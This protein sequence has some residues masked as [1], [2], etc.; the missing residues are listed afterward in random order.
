MTC[1]TSCRRGPAAGLPA[2]PKTPTAGP[3]RGVS[4]APGS[5]RPHSNGHNQNAVSLCHVC[6]RRRSRP[7]RG[8]VSQEEDDALTGH[9]SRPA[10]IQSVG[11]GDEG[12]GKVR[13]AGCLLV[14]DHG[15]RCRHIAHLP[16]QLVGVVGKGDDGVARG[17]RPRGGSRNEGH[18]K[19]PGELNIGRRHA[20]RLVHGNGI[21]NLACDVWGTLRPCGGGDCGGHDGGGSG[22]GHQAD[23]HQTGRPA[24]GG[25]WSHGLGP[26]FQPEGGGGGGGGGSAGGGKAQRCED[27]EGEGRGVCGPVSGAGLPNSQRRPP[28]GL[29]NVHP[30]LRRGRPSPPARHPA[31]PAEHWV[32]GARPSLAGSSS[33]R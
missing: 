31:P 29:L 15:R 5:R 19:G 7:I 33:P 22:K 24:P 12:S 2:Q 23:A 16:H 8:S 1:P 26:T 9:Q 3:T 18:H 14:G 13:P 25:G 21:V 20:A 11:G 10:P 27:G 6:R 4:G 32:V 28:G 30:I 17:L